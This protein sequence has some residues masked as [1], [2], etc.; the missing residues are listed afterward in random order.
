[1]NRPFNWRLKPSGIYNGAA[2][3]ISNKSTC[4]FTLAHSRRVRGRDD[5]DAGAW[6]ALGIRR[7]CSGF[8]ERVF[9]QNKACPEGIRDRR[10]ATRLQYFSGDSASPRGLLSAEASV[11]TCACASLRIASRDAAS[12]RLSTT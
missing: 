9:N 4:C 7:R 1:M 8:R 3:S 5:D 10:R 11:K 6:N 12:A 2:I